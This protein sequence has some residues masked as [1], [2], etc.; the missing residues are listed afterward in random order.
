MVADGFILSQSVL[1]MI[2]YNGDPDGY[3]AWLF[4]LFNQIRDMWGE[5]A[6]KVA[7]G[8]IVP[9]PEVWP[10]QQAKLYQSC[11]KAIY[12]LVIKIIDRNTKSGLTLFENIIEAEDEIDRDGRKL[13][14]FIAKG[15]VVS[16]DAAVSNVRAE[17]VKCGLKYTDTEEELGGEDNSHPHATWKTPK[18]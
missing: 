11:A 9:M 13:L 3:K 8:I 7:K 4:V 2:T 6:Y 14:E 16:G 12:G 15:K 17:I 1:K 18:R 10:E 5:Y